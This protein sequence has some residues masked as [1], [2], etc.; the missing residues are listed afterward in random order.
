MRSLLAAILSLFLPPRGAHRAPGGPVFRTA[1]P[2]MPPR[3]TQPCPADVL[4][5]DGLPLVRPY[6]AAWEC[7]RDA[8]D[9]RHVQRER[10]RAAVLATMG[11]DYVPVEAAA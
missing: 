2:C 6:L 3:R 9:R 4:L 10:R 5:A 8:L 11:Q 7:E 1:P